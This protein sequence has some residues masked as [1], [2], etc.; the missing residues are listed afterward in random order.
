MRTNAEML[1]LGW[2]VEVKDVP[3]VVPMTSMDVWKGGC[4]MDVCL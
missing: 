2:V 4:L 3:C 1:S